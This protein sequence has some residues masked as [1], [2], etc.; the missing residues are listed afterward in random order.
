VCL[1]NGTTRDPNAIVCDTNS[2]C[3]Q[4]PAT[5][6]SDWDHGRW[7][8]QCDTY[9]WMTGVSIDPSLNANA[10]RCEMRP[11]FVSY[12]ANWQTEGFSSAQR[13]STSDWDPGY[14]K[15][16]CPLNEYVSGYS[17]NTSGGGKG[18][19]GN[20]RCV[21]G[22]SEGNNTSC[23]GVTFSPNYPPSGNVGYV[24]GSSDWAPGAYKLECAGDEHM[25]GISTTASSG[26][27]IHG[28]LCCGGGTPPTTSPTGAGS[29]CNASVFPAAVTACTTN[30]NANPAS[31]SL[32]DYC[33]QTGVSTYAGSPSCAQVAYATDP[34]QTAEGG[35][36][37]T[38]GP[39]SKGAPS[40]SNGVYSFVNE[41]SNVRGNYGFGAGYDATISLSAN[42]STLKSTGKSELKGYATLFGKNVTLADLEVDGDSKPTIN[43]NLTVVGINLYNYAQQGVSVYDF[44]KS[45][46]YTFFSQSKTFTVGPVPV[47]VSG[48][49]AGTLGLAGSIGIQGNQISV[50]AGPYLDVT[51]TASAALGG[52][53]G[54]FTLDTGVEGSLTLF[55]ATVANTVTVAPGSSSVNTGASS[56]LTLT[57]LNGSIDLFVDGKLNLVF[58][59]YKKKWTYGIVSF[60]AAQQV[61]NFA[62]YNGSTAY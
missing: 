14:T 27:R 31:C 16:E 24:E 20:I 9:S 29:C 11:D 36:G 38:V 51:A 49:V 43:A 2:D 61:V 53:F 32:V 42:K 18:S 19:L 37:I 48:T 35:T 52:S 46:T 25:A 21:S 15:A 12:V 60:T 62:S 33:C 50:G 59:K 22:P 40:A 6:G 5:D 28:I 45:Y 23:H 8:K 17:V 55:N 58:A 10:F 1:S 3:K 39:K 30:P 57:E 4:Q 7:K 34:S 47:T 41:Y 13:S 56:N 44:E 54:P 26:G